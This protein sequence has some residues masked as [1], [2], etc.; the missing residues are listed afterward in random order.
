LEFDNKFG[1]NELQTFLMKTLDSLQNAK[2]YDADPS[3]LDKLTRGPLYTCWEIPVTDENIAAVVTA[4]EKVVDFWLSWQKDPSNEHRPGAPVNTQYVY[5]TKFKQNAFGS[6]LEEY[7]AIFGPEDG[8][9]L[10]VG[11]SGPL[12]EAYVGGGS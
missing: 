6:L 9:K 12:D 11:D 5:D 3:E 2:I 7:K 4:R 10:A 1:N 8:K